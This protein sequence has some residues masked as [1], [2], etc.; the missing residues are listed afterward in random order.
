ML[1]T[2]PMSKKRGFDGGGSSSS[3]SSNKDPCLKRSKDSSPSRAENAAALDLMSIGE[4]LEDLSDGEFGESDRA[5]KEGPSKYEEDDYNDGDDDC[6]L[7]NLLAKRKSVDR[8][9]IDSDSIPSVLLGFQGCFYNKADY[10]VDELIRKSCRT[11]LGSSSKNNIEW[12]YDIPSSVGP[13]PMAD[14]AL[15]FR[16]AGS[17]SDNSNDINKSV[18]I[19]DID[20]NTMATDNDNN[21]TDNKRPDFYSGSPRQVATSTH[22]GS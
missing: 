3:G 13:H 4:G 12:C 20:N 15:V 10:L 6:D 19:D 8:L 9:H 21:E 22:T 7:I 18:D 1:S 5:G 17:S 16:L 14:R 2:I 11:R